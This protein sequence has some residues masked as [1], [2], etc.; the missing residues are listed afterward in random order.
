M[1]NFDREYSN[2]RK[3]IKSI[4]Q[5]GDYSIIIEST[6]L[7]KSRINYILEPQKILNKVG[8]EGTKE[9][10]INELKLILE[11]LQKRSSSL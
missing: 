3:D 11:C 6:G 2:I 8:K 4:M 7:K 5:R 1:I 9:K 10:I